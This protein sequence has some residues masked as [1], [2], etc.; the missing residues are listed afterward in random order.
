MVYCDLAV[1]TDYIYTWMALVNKAAVQFAML[2]H[3]I[4]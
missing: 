1:L 4:K 2:I 3:N